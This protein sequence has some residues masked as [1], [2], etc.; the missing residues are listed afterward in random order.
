MLSICISYVEKFFFCCSFPRHSPHH[1][2]HEARRGNDADDADH[3]HRRAGD[4]VDH[5]L[6]LF[7]LLSVLFA[8]ADGGGGGGR[9]VVGS[10]AAALKVAVQRSN[11]LWSYC[12][13]CVQNCCH[14]VIHYVEKF[15][16]FSRNVDKT[17]PNLCSIPALLLLISWTWTHIRLR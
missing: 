16:T 2:G 13:Q 15:W 3:V 10:G 4:V 12:G 17:N 7:L 6:L 14:S 9:N 1:P 5:A 8:V 11:N